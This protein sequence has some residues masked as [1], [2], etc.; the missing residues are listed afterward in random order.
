MGYRLGDR[1]RRHLHGPR[2]LRRGV[3]P[4]RRGE[5]A[6][7]ARR[8]LRGHRPT[9]SVRLLRGGRR[10]RG[11]RGLRRPRHDRG[12]QCAPRAEGRAHRPH[13]DAG[14]PRLARDRP[15]E[16]ARALRPPRAEAGAA[17]APPPPLRGGRAR[18]WRT[19]RCALPLDLAAVEA[20]W[21]R[22]TPAVRG[23]AGR[24]AGD[25]LPL[26]LPRPRS[27]SGRCSSAPASG[28]SRRWSWRLPRGARRSSASTSGSAPPWP[29]PTSPRA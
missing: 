3:A 25:L 16:A 17:G 4:P 5:G 18:A 21:R 1:R 11:R 19:G 2:A 22:S 10:A 23:R 13:H 27:T 20:C 29:T 14:L 26:R 28:A 9:A 8:S 7:G 12:H 6:V 15:P 24:G